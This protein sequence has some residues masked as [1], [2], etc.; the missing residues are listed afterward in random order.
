[1]LQLRSSDRQAIDEEHQVNRVRT[2]QA[3]LHLWHHPQDVRLVMP[4]GSLVTL[5]LRAWRRHLQR[6]RTSNLE[7]MPQHAHDTMLSLLQRAG[8]AVQHPL[9]NTTTVRTLQ[10][11]PLFSMS[12]PQ[13]GG[14]VIGVERA[15]AVIT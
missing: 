13:P 4:N 2:I 8:E 15:L 9:L 12:R 6:A 5:V 14:H 3:V 7:A 1:C 10:T 11:L